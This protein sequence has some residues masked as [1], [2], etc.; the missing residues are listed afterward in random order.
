ML[1]TSQNYL[2][3]SYLVWTMNLNYLFIS[4]SYS[5]NFLINDYLNKH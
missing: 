1:N 4:L 2:L 3:F 5:S